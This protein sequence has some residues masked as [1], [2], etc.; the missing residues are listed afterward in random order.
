MTKPVSPQ[1]S[2]AAR[3]AARPAM[4]VDED[5]EMTAA[6]SG[7]KAAALPASTFAAPKMPK[8]EKPEITVPQSPQFAT[9]RRASMKPPAMTAEQ[10]AEAEAQQALELANSF[11]PRAMPKMQPGA[12]SGVPKVVPKKPTEIVEFNMPGQARHELEQAKFHEK[13]MR[14]A[15]EAAQQREFHAPE[16]PPVST[17]IYKGPAPAPAPAGLVEPKTPYLETK[18]RHRIAAHNQRQRERA[19]QAEEEERKRALAARAGV[20]PAST[21]PGY[22]P[23][24]ALPPAPPVRVTEPA[25][26]RM[27]S[28]SRAAERA[29]FEEQVKAKEAAKAEEARLERAQKEAE[30]AKAVK[31]LRKRQSFKA[32][33][34]V[35]EVRAS[36]SKPVT[37][38]KPS[39]VDPVSP[40]TPFRQHARARAAQRV[41]VNQEEEEADADDL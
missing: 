35:Q 25:P 2:T 10:R 12:C 20:V 37:Q 27:H 29:A 33:K 19:D 5:A 4:A 30:E 23:K 41:V 3:A 15:E 16:G 6:A 17:H 14:E 13:R 34:S 7:F 40:V 1:F 36:L 39:A 26:F 22:D 32:G 11:K 24:A 18:G 21:L 28:D 38:P 8:A 31:E 9:D